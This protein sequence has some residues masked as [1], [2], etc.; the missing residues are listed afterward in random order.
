VEPVARGQ[1]AVLRQD[2]THLLAIPVVGDDARSD[3]GA[4]GLY[5]L[6]FLP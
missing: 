1:V 6:Q 5:S 3:G 2:C 4:I